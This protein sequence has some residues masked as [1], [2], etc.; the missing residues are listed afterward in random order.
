MGP[1]SP[2]SEGDRPESRSA[3]EPGCGVTGTETAGVGVTGWEGG[4][5]V[6][7][8]TGGRV[9]AGSRGRRA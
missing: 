8:R 6:V 3:G 7:L 9:N 4:G 2:G 1:G 5:G